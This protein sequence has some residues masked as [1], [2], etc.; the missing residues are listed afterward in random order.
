LLFGGS[1][2]K[3][4]FVDG[5][6]DVDSLALLD[7]ESISDASPSVAREQ[8][9]RALRATLDAGVVQSVQAG[10]IAVRV[11][12]RDGMSVEILPALRRGE[13]F[14]ISSDD[15]RS[16]RAID[17]TAFARRLTELN[18]GLGG[19]LVPTIKLAKAI[20]GELPENQRL[21]GYH[22][23]ALALDAFRDYRGPRNPAAMLEHMFQSARSGVLHPIKDVT[24]QSSQVDEYLGEDFSTRRQRIAAS[25]AR[26]ARIMDSAALIS[27][28]QELLGAD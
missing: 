8:L 4:T 25:L 16:W 14:V 24:G 23:E 18:S 22:V 12:Y 20:I 15:G 5:M 26:I 2:A 11:E 10:D 6:S 21:S 27:Q 3:H 7:V 1:V 9:A 17:P 19:A 13:G 28:W